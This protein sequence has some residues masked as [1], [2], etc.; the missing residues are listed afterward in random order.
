MTSK[1]ELSINSVKYDVSLEQP[2]L[3]VSLS[4][5]GGQGS[6]GDSVTNAFIDGTGHLIIE[7]TSSSGVVTQVDAG[8]VS[9]EF[10]GGITNIDDVTITL[11]QNGDVLVYNSSL[12]V[13]ENKPHT[14]A[15]TSDLGDVDN[16]SRTD[17]SLLVYSQT[18]S[19]YEA[20]ATLQNQNTIILGGSF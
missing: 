20:T 8:D 2:K 19:K 7:V 16:T 1:Y 10:N 5:T 11:P 15:T 9:A 4:R 12:S 17:G 6:K 18:S 14:F 3:S 13:W